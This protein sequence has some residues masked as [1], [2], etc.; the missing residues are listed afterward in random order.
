MNE[1]ALGHGKKILRVPYTHAL[2]ILAPIEGKP[3]P[4]L[5]KG[6]IPVGCGVLSV[7][8]NYQH[9][10]F[11]FILQHESFEQTEPGTMLPEVEAVWIEAKEK[12]P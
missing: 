11:D 1:K 9:R 3:G 2:Q 10:T 6:T 8:E 5:P 12:K 4:T 7:H